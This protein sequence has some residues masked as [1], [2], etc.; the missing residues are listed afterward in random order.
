MFWAV[1]SGCGCCF[2]PSLQ[3]TLKPYSGLDQSSRPVDGES[4]WLAA[5]AAASR[6]LTVLLQAWAGPQ[7]RSPPLPG[8]SALSGGRLF[9]IFF[10][11]ALSICCL[12]RTWSF[13]ASPFPVLYPLFLPPSVH[14]FLT[15]QNAW[16]RCVPSVHLPDQAPACF[17]HL[18]RGRG[19]RSPSFPLLQTHGQ[20]Q[21]QQEAGSRKQGFA[22]LRLASSGAQETP[23]WPWPVRLGMRESCSWGETVGM[24][25]ENCWAGCWFQPPEK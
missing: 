17:S 7:D 11:L 14:W 21:R 5:I 2:E 20:K 3:L 10:P 6:Q 25:Q 9:P 18:L 12:H 23:A 15:L 19:T 16:H 22:L 8:S 13:P 24:I 4:G 1:G